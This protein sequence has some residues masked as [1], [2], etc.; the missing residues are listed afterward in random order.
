VHFY[1]TLWAGIDGGLAQPDTDGYRP[2]RIR[3]ID[4]KLR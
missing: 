2:A 1:G 4:I 3:D